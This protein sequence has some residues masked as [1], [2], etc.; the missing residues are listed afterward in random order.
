MRRPQGYAVLASPDG[1]VETDTFTCGHDQRI[2]K[3]PPG[4]DPA[5][6]GGLCKVC[7]Q[8]ICPQCVAKGICTP[9][10]QQMEKIEARDRFLRAA[11]I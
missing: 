2:V 6:I 3:V 9:W 5:S 8:L 10:E 11:G 1:V 4:A 7:M